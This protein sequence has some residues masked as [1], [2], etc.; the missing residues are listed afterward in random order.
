MTPNQ[1]IA[2][3]LNEGK[4]YLPFYVV[5]DMD[6]IRKQLKS[7]GFSSFTP[8]EKNYKY[9]EANAVLMYTNPAG[10]L[11]GKDVIHLSSKGDNS[12]RYAPEYAYP[13]PDKATESDYNENIFL[14]IPYTKEYDGQKIRNMINKD[15]HFDWDR[16]RNPDKF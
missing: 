2:K 3:S 10:D 8:D 15:N 4:Q 16:D 13:K 14:V 6:K 7:K 1:F 5:P 12:V 11:Y 9:S